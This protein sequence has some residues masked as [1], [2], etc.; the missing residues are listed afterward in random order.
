L[1]D[2]WTLAGLH[3]ASGFLKDDDEHGSRLASET[4]RELKDALNKSLGIAAGNT[5]SN[6]YPAA[7]YRRM[8]A[9]AV[10]SLVADYPLRLFSPGHP[11]LM[12][13]CEWLMENCFYKK[14]FFQ[15][16]IHSG[17]NCYLSL[18]IAQVLLRAGDSRFRDI[19]SYISEI[20]SPT[21]NWPEAV[22]PFSGGGCMGDGQ[23]GWAA[24]EW[25]MMMRSLF[26]R[27]EEGL[28]IIGSGLFPEWLDEEGKFF[29]GPTPTLFG[30][31]RVELEVDKENIF[32]TL[33]S[34]CPSK[35]CAK[36]RIQGRQNILI[37]ETCKTYRI[38]NSRPQES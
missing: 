29:F 3:E 32:I 35:C 4:A 38:T 27:E 5:N 33:M 7:P 36:V 30:N 25:I 1:D 8:D 18:T 6:A 12:N 14:G 13:T 11:Q 34:D 37:N 10:G 20:A 26:I 22:H 9:G 21:G 15:D 23:H 19:V 31:I 24:A 17:V 2:F 28:L 16:M